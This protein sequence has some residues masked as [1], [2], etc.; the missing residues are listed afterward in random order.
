MPIQL[1]RRELA[2][3]AGMFDGEGHAGANLRSRTIYVTVTQAG[4]ADQ[5]PFVLERFR[6]AVGGAGQVRGPVID[7]SGVRAPKW[8]FVAN[9]HEVVQFIAAAL[10]RCLGPVKRDQLHAALE[11]YRSIAVGTRREGVRLGRPL[12]RACKRGHD[13]SDALVSARGVRECRPCRR[14]RYAERVRARRVETPG[15]RYPDAGRDRR[16]GVRRRRPRLAP[17]TARSSI[18]STWTAD[19]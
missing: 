10:W 9:G 6:A 13:Y 4:L 3:A 15:R 17:R 11:L 18:R 14:V 19:R 1:V 16:R 8:R 7:P 5:P 2:W 12:N